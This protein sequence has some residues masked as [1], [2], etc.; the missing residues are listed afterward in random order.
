MS[1][2]TR[3]P[4]IGIVAK[5]PDKS[6]DNCGVGD[7][8]KGIA[9]EP[10][11][12]FFDSFSAAISAN[13]G[14]PIGILPPDNG[15]T[16]R[17]ELFTPVDYDLSSKAKSRLI[18]SI[19]LCDGII[20]QGGKTNDHYELFVA[21]Y[22]YKKNVPILGI[23]AG[24]QIMA[25][26]AGGKTARNAPSHCKPWE[27]HVHDVS[28]VKNTLLHSIVG[29]RKL[30]VNSV[31]NYYVS[32]APPNFIISALDSDGNIEAIEAKNK[33]FNLSVQ[34]HPE[35]LFTTNSRH[36]KI[37]K[38]LVDSAITYNTKRRKI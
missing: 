36:N 34:F 28:I 10:T 5:H 25:H 22:C 1:E 15:I 18:E 31:H 24:H 23:C 12:Y 37:F 4:I 13:G 33:L 3:K 8:S 16:P 6:C 32:I 27:T 21:N 35:C 17:N 19:N 7:A 2:A 38:A 11:T 29:P 26:V 20:L 14:I 30:P 9:A